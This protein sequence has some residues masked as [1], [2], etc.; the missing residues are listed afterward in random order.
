MDPASVLW[1]AAPLSAMAVAAAFDVRSRQVPD[2]CWAIMCASGIAASCICG[3]TLPA[4]L[5]AVSAAFVAAWVLCDRLSGIRSMLAVIPALLLSVAAYA[6]DPGAGAQ[7]AITVVMVALFYILYRTGVVRGGADAKCLMSV[8]I[9][10]PVYPSSGAV[11]IL[12]DAP[13]QAAAVLN[14]SVSVMAS[15]LALSMLWGIPV[16]VCNVR[17]G[18]I[19]RRMFHVLRMPAEKA[20]GAFVWPVDGDA[21][22]YDRSDAEE[23]LRRA[24]PGDVRVTPMIPFVLPLFAACAVTV[25]AGSPLFALI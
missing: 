5:S 15:A 21:V 16:V 13:M 19:D 1:V 7:S 2:S 20:R 6:V 9:V 3:G 14:P 24:G 11:P 4:L 8:A 12:W 25:L 23:F 17:A 18:R 10:Y 22:L